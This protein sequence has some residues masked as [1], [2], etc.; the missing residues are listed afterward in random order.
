MLNRADNPYRA[1]DEL[2]PDTGAQNFD[3]RPGWR[4]AVLFA[5]VALALGAIAL[6]LVFV[7][8]QLTDDYAVEFDRT[9]ERFEPIPSHDGR[10]IAAGGEVLAEDQQVF[11]LKVHYR[12]L[13][14]PPDPGWLKSQALSRLDRQARRDKA[15]VEAE[16]ARILE[17]RERLWREISQI[18]G[19]DASTLTTR[20]RGIQRRVEHI[21]QLVETRRDRRAAERSQPAPENTKPPGDLPLWEGL[22]N[23]VVTALTTPPVREAAEP[24]VVRE[25][26]DYHLLLSDLPIEA[27]VEIEAHP[28]LFPGTRVVVETRRVYPL[29]NVAPHLVG[30]RTPVDDEVLQ[31][32]KRRFPQGDPLDYQPGDRQGK[33]GLERFYERQLRGLRGLRKL[34]LDRRGEIIQIEDVREPRYGQDLVLSLSLPLQQSAEELLDDCLAHEHQDETNGKTLPIPPGGAIV[35]LDVRTGAVLAAASAPRFD[36]NLF[37]EHQTEAWN[38]VMADARKP[39]FHRAA[40]MALPPGSVF[41]VLSAIAFIESGRLDPYQTFHCQGYLD[42]P[43]RYRCL[44]FRNFGASHGDIS[45]VDALARSCNVYFFDAARRIGA[46]PIS[47]WGT[48]FG[49]GQP[50]GID[51]P[52][53]QGGN[54]PTYSTGPKTGRRT[55]RSSGDAL[56]LAIGQARLTTT[57]LQVARMMAVVANGGKLVV[58]KLVDSVG[59]ATLTQLAEGTSA[60]T[61]AEPLRG[62]SPRT[63]DV[64][65]RGLVQVVASPQGTGFKT[66][67]LPDVTIAGKT[68]T[69]EPGGGKPDHAWFAGFVPAERPRIAF[70]V[71]LENAGSGGHAAGPVARKFV[72]AMLTH[73]L[74]GGPRTAAP[75]AN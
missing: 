35:A 47:D 1:S 17:I 34:V 27:A 13:E 20:R 63:L 18:T 64:I 26:L 6:R 42:D 44:I 46:G 15:L 16:K 52:H 48:R 59:P 25:Q 75:S 10:I 54:L 19:Q 24:L 65:R 39:L 74:L 70:V 36:L 71:V 22:W 41:K 68:G 72:Q 51:L 33:A 23:V 62:L 8:T 56:Q 5:G 7:Q 67:R 45:L 3:G 61:S 50:T 29:G 43:D 9:V 11:G 53:E 55:D 58:P 37:I 38:D 12:W 14:E 28:E 2:L 40:E 31:T 32:R 30:F 66:V 49:F 21:Y 60:S 4:I 57:P 73:D 69:A